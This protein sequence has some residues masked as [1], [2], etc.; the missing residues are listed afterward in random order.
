M[1]QVAL[2]EVM[3]ALQEKNAVDPL[4]KILDKERTPK[5]VKEKIE[6]SISTLL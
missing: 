1:V 3:V 6:E 5:E 2:A 4:K